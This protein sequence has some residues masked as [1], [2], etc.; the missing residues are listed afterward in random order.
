MVKAIHL[1][2]EYEENPV[3]IGTER[4]AF[5]WQIEA[6]GGSISQTAYQIAVA[7]DETFAGIVWDTGKREDSSCLYVEYE[8][9]ALTS[10]SE[11]Y[12]KVRLWDESG[13]EGTF[14]ETG[15]F[16]TSL[17]H[18]EEEW[19]GKWIS[20]ESEAD[21]Y[22][23]FGQWLKKEFT[24]P[25]GEISSAWLF[26]TAHGIYEASINSFRA[27][28]GVLMP[29]WTEYGKRLLFQMY[30]VKASLHEGLNSICAHIGP[31]WY[32]GDLA[33]WI[34]LRGVYGH[35]TGFNAMLLIRYRDGKQITVGTDGTWRW[36]RSAVLYSEIYHG[37]VKDG[38]RRPDEVTDWAFV[39]ETG[40]ETGPLVPQDGVFVRRKETVIPKRLFRTPNGE[41]VLDF[42]QNM[43]G[44]V[45]IHVSG[46]AGE[47]VELSHAEILDR[48]GNVYTGNLRE[49]R[50]RVKYILHGGEEETF[51]PS[52]T[53]QGFQ[54][55]RIDHW[56]GTPKLQDFMGVV[57]Y[58]DLRQAGYFRCSN[59]LINRLEE[60]IRWGM[61]GNFVDIPTDCP[62]RD[63]RMGWTGD[64]QVFARTAS[65]L[66]ETAPFFRKWLRDLKAAQL[67]D[68][69]IP[70]VVPDI[71]T[72]QD[73]DVRNPG[74]NHSASGWGDAAV[75]CPYTAY[76]YSGD[77]RL[78]QEFY[79]MM[80]MWV[81]YVRKRAEGGVIWDS[82][83]QYG[84]W[85]ALDAEPGS[86]FGKTPNVLTAT[87]YYAHSVDLVRKT[88]GILKKEED[89]RFYGQLFLQIQEAFQKR[90]YDEDGRMKVRTQTAHVLALAFGL[91]GERYREKTAEDLAELIEEWN[92]LSTG[93]LG[94][95]HICRVLADN[96]R[97][98]L[99]L[100]LLTKTEYPSWLYPVTKGATTIWEHWDSIRPDGSFWSDGMNSF[101]HYAYGSIGDWIYG[102]LLG[103]DTS[104]DA[105]GYRES[106]VAPVP[107][108]GITWAEGGCYTPYG[109][110]EVKW[111]VVDGEFFLRVMVPFGTACRVILPGKTKPHIA[112]PGRHEFR[113][114]MEGRDSSLPA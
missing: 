47:Y 15:R 19:K 31:G 44:W 16:T 96:G 54:Y 81:E 86:R 12:W 48:A 93:F 66:M 38:R 45:K 109:L 25:P 91:A 85:L 13:R 64:I 6:D 56:P 94:T 22:T 104:E 51:E 60:N 10:A 52:F 58:S 24:L 5:S 53:W 28:D 72:F 110:L 17:L 27:G 62:Q 42:G 78:L 4:P 41:L 55:V 8:G 74:A 36:S 97:A 113:C 43:V 92:G 108:G 88:A 70:Y 29:G 101:N 46:A 79:P 32:K 105:P 49:A 37:E 95:P 59:P 1:T 9:E 106:I 57:V 21:F 23:S 102:S 63:E 7:S 89:A 39:R 114:R 112:G 18:A 11:C 98:D 103:M 2:C 34:H 67:P 68:G 71:L 65:C 82:G 3:G 14:S 26:A 80:K 76:R 35:C 111:Q 87:A 61:K 40:E 99:A 73:R 77:K 83:Y 75:V 50:Q 107:G 69:G 33:G 84:D 90:F 30:D 100:R 20:A